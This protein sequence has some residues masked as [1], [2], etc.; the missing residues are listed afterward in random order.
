MVC[1]ALACG[2]LVVGCGGEKRADAPSTEGN[3]MP[4]DV[5]ADMQKR[6]GGVSGPPKASG[7][8]AG[9]LYPTS[10]PGLMKGGA[11]GAPTGPK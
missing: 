7:S 6:M 8:K 4:A 10:G 2:L 9:T 11:P 5:Q 1:G 3:R